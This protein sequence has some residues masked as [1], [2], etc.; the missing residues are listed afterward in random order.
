MFYK[1]ADGTLQAWLPRIL[2]E[3]N[4]PRNI[5]S[6]V[7]NPNSICIA[8]ISFSVEVFSCDCPKVGGKL[9]LKKYLLKGTL[10]LGCTI[11]I[12]S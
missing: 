11:A 10:A 7:I 4:K 6:L 1:G 3:G 12:V 2:G 8:S 5:M 9:C